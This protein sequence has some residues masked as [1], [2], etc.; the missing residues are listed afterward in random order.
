MK[1]IEQLDYYQ[2]SINF[3]LHTQA[4]DGAICWEQNTKLDPWDHIESAMALTVD[5]FQIDQ[6]EQLIEKS[7]SFLGRLDILVNN[8][9]RVEI[10]P[11]LDVT[12]TEWYDT[13]DLNLKGAY[14]CMQ[15]G[16]RQMIRQGDGGRIINM[17]SIS[18][19]HGRSDSSV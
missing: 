15:E 7:V 1:E 17:S 9:G 8:A 10:K 18:G 16:A 6:I 13:M 12:E 2:D 3:I 19:R 11:F 4:D 14:F 5:L